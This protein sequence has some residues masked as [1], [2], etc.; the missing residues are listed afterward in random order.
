MQDTVRDTA[1]ER[2]SKLITDSRD[3]GGADNN[4][5]AQSHKPAFPFHLSLEE[6]WFSLVLLT[7]VVYSTIWSVQAVNWVDHLNV[8]TLTTLLGL[9]TGVVAAKQHRFPPLAVHV[10]V[11]LLAL[12]IA[13]WQTAGAF[14][15]GNTAQL[16]HGMHQWFASVI[17]GG[18]GEDDSIFLFLITLLGFLL[19]YSSA[20]LVYRTRSPWLMIVA[21]AVVLLINLRN[22]EDGYIVFL[23]VFLMASLLL[24]LRMNLFESTRRWRR[25]RNRPTAFLPARRAGNDWRAQ[26]LST[27]WCWSISRP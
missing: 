24:L 19:A 16:A 8:L 20:W 2:L 4:K 7:I 18:T 15:G 3:G 14:D 17:N 22:V 13:F 6:G 1:V 27:K 10:V 25:Q 26:S 5:D 12:L 9:I 21:N 11:V 23:V